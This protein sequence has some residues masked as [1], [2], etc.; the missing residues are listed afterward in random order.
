MLY[1][2]PGTD[3][4]VGNRSE[5]RTGIRKQANARCGPEKKGFG[6]RVLEIVLRSF[7]ECRKY[8]CNLV[9][10]GRNFEKLLKLLP[11]RGHVDIASFLFIKG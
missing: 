4:R 9:R 10:N 5:L 11:E 8:N 3:E 6:V 2:G 1:C 7:R